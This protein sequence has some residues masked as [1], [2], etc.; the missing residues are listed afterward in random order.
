[1]DGRSRKPHISDDPVNNHQRLCVGIERVQAVHEHGHAHARHTTT[2]NGMYI[3]TQ[4]VLNLTVNT[5]FIRVIIHSYRP[6]TR[7]CP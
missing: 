3:G 7:S 2:R 1:M 4:L 5:D 6:F